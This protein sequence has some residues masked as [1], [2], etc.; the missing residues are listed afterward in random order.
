MSTR[1]SFDVDNEQAAERRD[2]RSCLTRPIL[3]REW[4]QGK[5]IT[6]Q[7]TMSRT[8]KL[9]IIGVRSAKSDD[10]TSPQETSRSC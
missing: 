6:A 2:N 1:F 4:A 8:G 10:H 7:L 3:G 5:M 9:F